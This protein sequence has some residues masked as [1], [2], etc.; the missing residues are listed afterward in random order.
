MA[1]HAC[2]G[3]VHPAAS[4]CPVSTKAPTIARAILML[5]GLTWPV[6]PQHILS[7][8]PSR[9]I[10]WLAHVGT[11]GLLPWELAAS[12]AAL[13]QLCTCSRAVACCLLA[14]TLSLLLARALAWPPIRPHLRGAPSF[15]FILP[16]CAAL[17]PL[18]WRAG[19]CAIVALDGVR[20]G[21]HFS[22]DDGCARRDRCRGQIISRQPSAIVQGHDSA[23]RSHAAPH[24]APCQGAASEATLVTPLPTAHQQDGAPHRQYSANQ[25]RTQRPI[26]SASDVRV[27]TRP[28]LTPAAHPGPSNPRGW[29]YAR[30]AARGD[31]EIH[32]SR[33]PHA[34]GSEIGGVKAPGT[35][36]SKHHYRQTHLGDRSQLSSSHYAQYRAG[37][38][39]CACSGGAHTGGRSDTSHA[40]IH[41]SAPATPVCVKPAPAI[42]TSGTKNGAR[43][44]TF[45]NADT[46]PFEPVETIELSVIDDGGD[47]ED[48][49]GYL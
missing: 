38:Q 47:P 4:M 15:F 23:A 2:G 13:A 37:S 33:A 19:D 10:E 36:T 5:S 48:I 43:T 25:P 9:G 1:V 30:I 45:P 12:V 11:C 44:G 32:R 34:H 7:H 26:R 21:R 3:P 40:P 20:I 8:L 6:G 49:A 29:E 39:K 41:E 27:A 42:S 28:H 46:S 17:G 16:S 31:H 35:C 18:P 24:A 14:R 22:A